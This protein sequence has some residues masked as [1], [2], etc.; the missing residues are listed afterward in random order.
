VTAN[1][2]SICPPVPTCKTDSRCCVVLFLVAAEG[3]FVHRHDRHSAHLRRGTR[4][5]TRAPLQDPLPALQ[6][7]T[8]PPTC[9]HHATPR[10]LQLNGWLRWLHWVLGCRP[11]SCSCARRRRSRS[12][13]NTAAGTSRPPST[14]S[15]PTS[16]SRNLK[17]VRAVY[18]H[19]APVTSPSPPH[20]HTLLLA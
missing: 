11:C 8:R 12:W 5:G 17:R 7:G 3:A 2:L 10:L 13:S 19:L 9:L 20:R 4:Q 1:T 16:R 15:S 14:S 18:P 6:N